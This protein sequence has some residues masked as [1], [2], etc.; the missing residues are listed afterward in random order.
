M[1]L[2]HPRPKYRP[3]VM[4][5]SSH[6]RHF[7][8]F[9]RLL[10]PDSHYLIALISVLKNLAK[11]ILN[12]RLTWLLEFNK[13]HLASPKWPLTTDQRYQK[14]KLITVHHFFLIY[15]KLFF[16]FDVTA[17]FINAWS[18]NKSL[19]VFSSDCNHLMPSCDHCKFYQE[20]IF[21]CGII[22]IP[23]IKFQLVYIF[24]ISNLWRPMN[25]RASTILLFRRQ[26][27]S[28]HTSNVVSF[29][30]PPSF[31]DSTMRQLLKICEFTL[32]LPPPR[33]RICR[34]MK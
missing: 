18:L 4:E 8:S 15:N 16:T 5:I 2:R 1:I 20:P 29:V 27:V 34:E 9:W 12:K 22:S 26:V 32:L 24:F 11:Q 13:R 19:L 31:V 30:N 33:L 3:K 6:S 23:I 7:K 10:L 17:Y 14:C 25:L 28:L 21:H